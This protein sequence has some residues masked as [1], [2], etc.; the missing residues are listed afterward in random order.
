[1]PAS[2]LHVTADQA[3]AF[4][5]TRNGIS[6]PFTAPLQAVRS[7]VAIQA[8]Y[9]ASIPLAVHARCPSAPRTWTEH[10]L[11]HDHT[12]V[13]TWCL[14]GTLHALAAEDLAL[15]IGSLGDR[16]HLAI[17][18]LMLNMCNMDAAAWHAVEQETMQ[19]L[20]GGPLDRTA[21]HAAV[22]R[23]R[24]VP[25]SGWGE[26]V[27]G[28]AYRGDLLMVGSKGSRPVFARR[29]TWLPDLHFHP[30]SPIRSHEELLTRYLKTFAPA[31]LTDVAHWTGLSAVA[32]REAAKRTAR[33]LTPVTI[34]GDTSSFVMLSE[35]VETL[36]HPLPDTPPVTLLP[37][38]DALMLAWKDPSRVLDGASHKAV[39]RPAGQIEATVLTQGRVA[40][41]WRMAGTATR[42]IYQVTPLR[43]IGSTTRRKIETA[44]EHLSAWSGAQT[45]TVTWQD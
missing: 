33:L 40:A 31:T 3:R 19:A 1:M 39:F 34:E 41:T 38:F 27:K 44:F 8:Q 14:R 42:R 13:R 36:T 32:V 43:R 35:D 7:V 17:E 2:S 15:M 29:D 18:R 6:H 16:Y 10:A 20:A 4:A 30:S 9:D 25:W 26:D 37:K 23:L 11:S 45:A 5:L 12:L 21:L 28:L 24:D 22:P